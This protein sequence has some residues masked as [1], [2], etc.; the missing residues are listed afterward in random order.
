MYIYILSYVWLLVCVLSIFSL[1]NHIKE[2]KRAQVLFF[3]G[4][5]P[6]LLLITLRG[7]IGTDT[8]NYFGMATDLV[9]NSSKSFT[10]YDIEIGFYF[11]L[12]CLA[13]VF[14]DPR[15]VINFISFAIASYAF[16]LFSKNVRHILIFSILIAPVFLLDM[17]MN[18]L[19]YG[20]A[21][22]IAK[23]ASDQ[24]DSKQKIAALF[25]VIASISIQV[26]GLLV[27]ALLAAK[28][29]KFSK[30]AF[31]IPLGLIFG[32]IF[33][34]RI[35]YKFQSYQTLA[36]PGILSGALP[37][38]IF[39]GCYL[40]LMIADK[41]LGFKF[42][43]LLILEIAS[44]LLAKVS[45]AGLRFQLLILFVFFCQIAA[46]EL[47]KYNRRNWVISFFLII[48]LIG[49]SGK[50]RN[51]SDGIDSTPT[52]FLPYHFFWDVE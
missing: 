38:L 2:I 25:L 47:E 3:L 10:E 9:E 23:H 34:D 19:R 11:L 39:L 50:L 21:F 15:F 48:G 32:I 17:S 33:Q 43:P 40:N 36:S 1:P 28:H 31:L 42:L 16:F 49:F 13:F 26:S 52:S 24:Y 45:Y 27:F 30:L 29:F 5:L 20:L 14:N 44:F 37:L 18:G 4:F 51:F 7:D 6:T 12:E 41:K 35:L 46:I 8:W 22:L